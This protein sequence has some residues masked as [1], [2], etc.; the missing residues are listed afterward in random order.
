M[1]LTD[2]FV[3]RPFTVMIFG[4]II[5]LGF[6]AAVIYFETY[7]PSPVTDLDYFIQNDRSTLLYKARLAAEA[8]I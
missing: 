2:L 1:W 5:I 4:A 3:K 8:E 6:T 7:L